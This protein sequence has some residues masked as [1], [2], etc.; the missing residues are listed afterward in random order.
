MVRVGERRVSKR[1][2]SRVVEFMESRGIVADFWAE[3]SYD[4]EVKSYNCLDPV[5]CVNKVT[6]KFGDKKITVNNKYFADIIFE[7]ILP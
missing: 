5:I 7:D 1:S 4:F 6:V 2:F 3:R